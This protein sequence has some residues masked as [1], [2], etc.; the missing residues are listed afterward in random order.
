MEMT[1]NVEGDKHSRVNGANSGVGASGQGIVPMDIE[2]T[3][4]PRALEDLEILDSFSF[5]YFFLK[6]SN[7]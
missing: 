2:E 3:S 6:L 1:F 7:V 4:P 5:N